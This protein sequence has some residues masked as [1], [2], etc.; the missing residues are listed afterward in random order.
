MPA[1]AKKRNAGN[2]CRVFKKIWTAKYFFTE[3]KGKLV[4]LIRGTQIALFQ[5]Y[6]WNRHYT[7]K[8]HDEYRSI[9][10]EDHA[11]KSDPLLAKPQIQQGPF[12]PKSSTKYSKYLIWSILQWKNVGGRLSNTIQ[13]SHVD[14]QSLTYVETFHY[15]SPETRAP[16]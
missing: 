16:G 13:V 12:S 8:N 2:E 9:P 7:A 11:R 1:H 14:Y 3:I 6:N 15:L 4:C 5:G 10:D